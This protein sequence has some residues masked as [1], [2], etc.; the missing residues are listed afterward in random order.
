MLGEFLIAGITLRGGF[1]RCV[2]G[3]CRSD[4]C[5]HEMETC[6]VKRD[7]CNEAFFSSGLNGQ[8]T[9]IISP[10]FTWRSQNRSRISSP[11]GSRRRARRASA[12]S[13]ALR[14]LRHDCP[15]AIRRDGPM[16]TLGPLRF[17]TCHGKV[18]WG[19]RRAAGGVLPARRRE[20]HDPDS[21]QAVAPR[22][23]DR[24]DEPS[25][26]DRPGRDNARHPTAFS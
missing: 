26:V 4:G 25:T 8:F 20:R 7:Y 12:T 22:T 10:H 21:L 2:T 17:S 3:I 14:F 24:H 18:P 1:E 5:F 6:Q 13:N 15:G 19:G 16:R 11:C 23:R 9:T